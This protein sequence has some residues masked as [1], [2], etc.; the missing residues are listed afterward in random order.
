MDFPVHAVASEQDTFSLSLRLVSLVMV[1]SLVHVSRLLMLLVVGVMTLEMSPA[2][3]VQGVSGGVLVMPE[4][5]R[6][7]SVG[8]AI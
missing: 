6:V 8:G 5:V 1:M 3:S 4:E 2:H 7:V